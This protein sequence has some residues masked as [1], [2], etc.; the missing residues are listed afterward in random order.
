MGSRMHAT[1]A[2]IS[3]CIPTVGLAYSKKFAGVY[4]TVGIDDCV[5]DLR[6]MDNDKVLGRVKV[7]YEKSEDIKQRLEKN[8]PVAKQ[9]VFQLFDN[10]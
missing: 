6:D 8:I 3:Q 9:K 7:L 1:I 2:A 5:V 4:E 10:I